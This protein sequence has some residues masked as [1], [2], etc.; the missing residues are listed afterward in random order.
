MSKSMPP[1]AQ[2]INIQVA[3][4]VEGGHYNNFLSVFHSEIEFILDFGMFLPGKNVIKIQDRIVADPRHAKQFL[5]ALHE[6]IRKYEEKFG[7]IEPIKMEQA[8]GGPQSKL[9]N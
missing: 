9:E 1:E 6:N 2:R 7:E 8:A 5:L 3:P 4:E